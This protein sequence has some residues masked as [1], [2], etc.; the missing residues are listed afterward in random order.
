MRI[1]PPKTKN[2][3][4]YYDLIDPLAPGL[5]L[6]LIVSF[7]AE[8]DNDYYDSIKIFS[9]DDFQFE[10]PLQAHSPA[11]NILFKPFVNLGFIPIGKTRSE[12]ITFENEGI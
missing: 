9:G 3:R 12:I 2:F 5:A 7:T 1:S 6:E 11:A 8:K 10:I 4:C